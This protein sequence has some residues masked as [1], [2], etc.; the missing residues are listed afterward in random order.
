[1]PHNIRVAVLGE[2]DHVARLVRAILDQEIIPAENMFLSALDAPAVAA[3]SGRGVQLCENA[4]AAVVNSEI[5]L[6]SASRREMGS[7]LAPISQCTRGRTLVAICDSDKVNVEYV[8]ER[9]VFGTEIIAATIHKREDGSL[10]A[11]YEIDKGVRLFL[12]Q[13]C[14]DMVDVLCR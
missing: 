4:A 5:V 9:V 2:D 3:A 12:H 14:R 10:Y 1:M 11:T 6:V 8:K 7:E 13:P